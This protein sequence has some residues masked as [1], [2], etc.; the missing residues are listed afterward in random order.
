MKAFHGDSKIKAKYLKRVR[1]HLAADNLIRGKGWEDGKGCAIGCTLEAYDHKRYETE[2]GIPEWLA[3]VED[4]LFE[5]MTLK[6]SKT[7]PEVFL[8][9][10]K[11]GVDLSKAKAPFMIIVLKSA[12]TSFDHVK[13][14]EV[15][16]VLDQTIMLWK[17]G[18][19]EQEWSAAWS[20][21]SSVA[22][23][24]ARS[25][26]W[27]A[28]RRAARSAAESAAWSAGWN[29]A[30]SAAENAAES[31]AWSAER[32]AAW[33]VAESVA[34]SVA[35]SVAWSAAESAPWNAT[36]DYFANEL[37]KILKDLK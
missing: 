28:E 2:L 23:S 13:Y 12:L 21:A 34:W 35:R 1:N 6:K 31:V 29:A 18:G 33:S 24:A 14:P 20:A 5:G 11:P 36:Y 8:K 32:R 27:S 4:T 15:K 10:V 25:A 7:W 19:T 17:E 3:R 22:S 37:I 26:A 30:R 9:A 16:K